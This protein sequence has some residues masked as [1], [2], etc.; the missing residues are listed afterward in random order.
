ML[1]AFATQRGEDRR[2]LGGPQFEQPS[3][4]G[5]YVAP[6]LP[7]APAKVTPQPGIKFGQRAVVLRQAKVLHPAPDILVEFANPVGHRD[8]PASPGEL[9]QL[10]TKVLEGLGGPI[11]TRALKGKAQE[12]TLL[13]G[14]DRTLTMVDLQLEVVLKKP[15]QDG[16]HALTCAL[17]VDD[18]EK[19]VA[20]PFTWRQTW[21][22]T[23]HGERR[24]LLC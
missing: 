18:D 12:H 20:I 23:H 6:L 17:A 7:E 22:Y 8:T 1:R 15:S 16:F 11:D 24:S 3:D 4:F 5:A 10:V 13:G 21:T 14:A 9:A 19:V 2:F